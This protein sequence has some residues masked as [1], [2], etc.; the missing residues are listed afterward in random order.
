MIVPGGAA[1]SNRLTRIAHAPGIPANR[2]GAADF[3]DAPGTGR[4]LGGGLIRR[5]VP[6]VF[7]PI[8]AGQ[9]VRPG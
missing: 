2:E 8:D 5:A 6:F 3:F 4:W 9:A 7:V 1:I